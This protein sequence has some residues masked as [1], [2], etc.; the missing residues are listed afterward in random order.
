MKTTIGKAISKASELLKNGE[1][2]GVPTETVYGL[3]ANALNEDAVVKIF[4]VK[5]RPRFDPLIMHLDRFENLKKYVTEIPSSFEKLARSHCPG[6]LTFVI[7]KKN[8]V[9]DIVTSGNPIVAV[10]IPSHPMIRELLSEVDFP[11]AA[12]SANPFGYISPTTANHVY[13]QLKGKISYILDGGPCKVGLEST[14]LGVRG[15]NVVV[16]RLGGLP[17][18]D[19][20]ASTGNVHLELNT[21]GLPQSPGQ[22]KSHYA[23]A[24]PLFIDNPGKYLKKFAPE[25]I[26]I[27]AFRQM[28][29]EFPVEHQR[30]LSPSGNLSEAAANFF[31]ALRELDEMELEIII[32]EKLPEEGLGRAIN[33]RLRKASA[34]K[35]PDESKK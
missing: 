5:N 35:E 24:T 18:E 7:P 30:I 2:I 33:D 31:Y 28:Y 8:L 29:L 6:P 15:K 11:L 13:R 22:L 23:P 34:R 16:L 20:K 10:R 1:V 25:K 26:G 21:P 4:E 3:A 19:I 14:I 17:L 27:I 12:P 9:P 32:A